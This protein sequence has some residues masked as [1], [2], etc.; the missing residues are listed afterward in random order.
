MGHS[1]GVRIEDKAAS[2]DQARTTGRGGR[3]GT[4][5][6]SALHSVLQNIVDEMQAAEQLPLPPGV[7]V[8]NLLAQY[9]DRI[10]ELAQSAAGGQGLS[11]GGGEIAGLARRALQNDSVQAAL[12]ARR[13]WPEIPVAAAIDTDGG[14][15]VIEGIIDLLYEDDDGQLV[16]LDYKSDNIEADKLDERMKQHYQWQGAAYAAAVERA[17]GREVADVQFLFVRLDGPAR[18]IGNWR[19]LVEEVAR[20]AA[21]P[22]G[23]PAWS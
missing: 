21:A 8:A 6:G 1:D 2:P 14:P 3:G 20:R 18:S 16:I 7:S 22:A 23:M 11:G 12:R 13:L 5:F 15:V 4:A 19:C 9:G 17:T 10:R